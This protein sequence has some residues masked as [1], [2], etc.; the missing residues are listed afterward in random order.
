MKIINAF[1]EKRNLGVST[2]EMVIDSKDP[3]ETVL[4]EIESIKAE[5]IVIK[6]PVSRFDINKMLID[7]NFNY[8]EGSCNFV[9]N[10]SEAKLS[11]FQERLNKTI[12]YSPMNS[13]ETVILF[14]EIR[15]GLFKT[16]RIYLDDFF[17]KEK[18]SE[19]YVKWIEDE[20]SRTTEIFKITLKE[21]T[22]GF[23]SFKQTDEI[24]YYPF[25][26]GLYEKY[27]QSGLG[28]VTL[29]KPIE[30]AIKRG[31]KKIST[32]ASTNNLPVI[33]AHIQQGFNINEILYVFVKHI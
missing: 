21:E 4:K 27:A 6:V 10:L 33:K 2:V 1:W 8:I 14:E 25:L 9:L 13:D 5:Y 19:R 15:K 7:K 30:E 24:T 17:T 32:Y 29:R 28:F 31:G 3:L 23:F 11:P 18:A 26:A 20:L 16:D 12:Y 22:I